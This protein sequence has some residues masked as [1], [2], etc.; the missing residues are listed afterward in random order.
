[1]TRGRLLAITTGFALALWTAGSAMAGN[2]VLTGHDDDF[3]WRFDGPDA[4][5]QPLKQAAAMIAFARSGASDPTLPVLVFDRTAATSLSGDDELTRLFQHLGIAIT[6]VDP[7]N[8][9]NI[10]D[11]LFD[12]TKYSAFA[13]ASQNS[14]GGCD[15]APG[16]NVNIAAHLSAISDFLN[17]G[18]GI[19]GMSGAADAAA[20]AYVPTTTTV[21]PGF[22]PSTGYV[23]TAFGASLGIP[24]VNGDATHNFF[25]EPGTAGMSSA[26]GVVE[27]LGTTSVETVACVG[28]TVSGGVL[29]GVPE[30]TSIVLLGSLVVGLTLSIRKRVRA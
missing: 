30:P 27:R 25:N 26:Y 28:C 21:P 3:H 22:P 1:M 9:A 16:D 4:T 8:A 5:N 7:S 6:A 12:P 23:Q 19:I 2:I 15:L 17:A 13:V 11:A 18:G 29:T 20:Y 24:A 14:C 10:T